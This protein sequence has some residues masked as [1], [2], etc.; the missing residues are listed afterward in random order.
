[1]EKNKDTSIFKNLQFDALQL[2]QL[3]AEYW[4]GIDSLLDMELQAELLKLREKYEFAYNYIPI[5]LYEKLIESEV[6]KSESFN[7]SENR[8][9]NLLDI[10]KKYWKMVGEMFYTGKEKGSVYEDLE[11][12][13]EKARILQKTL[14]DL[15]SN[16]KQRIENLKNE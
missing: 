4:Q 15:A 16:L 14:N 11:Q 13:L 6:V 5:N 3:K 2:D 7:G 8:E 1:M 9:E 12:N 10:Q